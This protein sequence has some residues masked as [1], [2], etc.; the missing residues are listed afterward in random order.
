MQGSPAPM[1]QGGQQEHGSVRMPM[2]WGQ[3][4]AGQPAAQ[5]LQG[6]AEERSAQR[7]ATQAAARRRRLDMVAAWS[8]ARGTGDQ[9]SVVEEAEGSDEDCCGSV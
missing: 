6:R 4:R 1:A 8:G 3:L 7:S 2:P 5:I 9:R